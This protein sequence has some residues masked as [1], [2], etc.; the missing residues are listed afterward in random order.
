MRPSVLKSCVIMKNWNGYW[1]SL[2][3]F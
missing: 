3:F 1:I 2:H